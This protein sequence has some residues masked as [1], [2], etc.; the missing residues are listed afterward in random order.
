M[1]NESVS[2][3]KEGYPI[4]GLFALSALVF[5]CF[6][7]EFGMFCSL[8]FLV[9][10]LFSVFFF[11][12]PERVVPSAEGLAVSPADGKIV[13]I[14]KREDPIDGKEKICIS[15]F[16]NVF[17]VHVNRSPVAGTLQKIV[18]YPGKFMNAAFDKAS[19]DNERCVYQVVDEDGLTWEFVQ[20]SG[21]IARRIVCRADEGDK[22]SRGERFGMI[23][24]GS[25]V[26]VYLP[27][28]YESAV[29]I[30][31]QVFA[32]QSVLAGKA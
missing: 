10:V 14:Q 12:D 6:D 11:R 5:A 2:I 31:E 23:R 26:D 1:K 19:T 22:L 17:S 3:A 27:D 20:I 32:G 24:F 30:G 21:L 9:L 8:I 18:Y 13:R 28:E 25:R 16:M 29:K 4:I 15:I 7:S